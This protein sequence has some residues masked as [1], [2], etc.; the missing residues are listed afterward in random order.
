MSVGVNHCREVGVCHADG[1]VA[2][3]FLWGGTA[4]EDEMWQEDGFLA[5]APE[6]TSLLIPLS[7]VR[8]VIFG[9]MS[10]L[11]EFL[12]AVLRLPVRRHLSL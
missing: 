10:R 2:D 6:K 9:S 5:V 8:W 3:R 7:V 12:P 4:S 1:F 11:I